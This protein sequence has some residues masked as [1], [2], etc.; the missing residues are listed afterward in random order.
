MPTL[1]REVDNMLIAQGRKSGDPIDVT[2]PV[3]I[4]IR[5]RHDKTVIWITADDETG[6]TFNFRACKIKTLSI[7]QE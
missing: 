2:G 3:N 6:R 5:I 7:V 1:E 4:E